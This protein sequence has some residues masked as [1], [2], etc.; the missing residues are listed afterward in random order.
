MTV[1]T[2]GQ[3]PTR[4]TQMG[5]V[6]LLC[7]GIWGCRSHPEVTFD[8]SRSGDYLPFGTQIEYPDAC[9]Q[10]ASAVMETLEPNTVRNPEPK[11]T[12]WELTLEEAI[13]VA[14]TNSEVMRDMGATR[15]GRARHP[16]HRIRPG[17]AGGESADR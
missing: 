9:V 4:F 7:L 12:Y 6:V 15:R 3:K 8:E 2:H 1:H 14:L 13:R 11:H 17:V 16:E 10:P 5:W